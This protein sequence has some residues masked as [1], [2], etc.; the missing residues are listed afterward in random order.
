MIEFSGGVRLHSR[1]RA[2]PRPMNGIRVPVRIPNVPSALVPNAPGAGAIESRRKPD[3]WAMEGRE[4]IGR[5]QFDPDF[6]VDRVAGEARVARRTRSGL[7]APPPA[8][9]RGY[10]EEASP[11]AEPRRPR[12][13][14]ETPYPADSAQDGAAG[15]VSNGVCDAPVRFAHGSDRSSRAGHAPF[16]GRASAFSS[17]KSGVNHERRICRGSTTSGRSGWPGSG[18]G[19]A[20]M[21]GGDRSWPRRQEGCNRR[22]SSSASRRRHLEPQGDGR[23]RQAIALAARRPRCRAPAPADPPPASYCG[24]QHS[25]E[26]RPS[27]PGSRDSGTSPF[28]HDSAFVTLD[29]ENLMPFR[30]TVSLR[31]VRPPHRK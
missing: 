22:R 14:R 8:G 15:V 31:G 7:P 5:V 16:R 2:S 18:P 12:R 23:R 9:A 28:Q 1:A 6:T 24:H 11:H 30:P 26:L 25:R 4:H 27:D 10:R 19:E 21:S 17:R 13:C 20:E 3:A 29:R